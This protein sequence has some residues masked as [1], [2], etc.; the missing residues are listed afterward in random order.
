MVGPASRPAPSAREQAGP[1][2]ERRLDEGARLVIAG[3]LVF[4]DP[5]ALAENGGAG[6]AVAPR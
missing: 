5:D 2:G 3:A 1:L 4:A 6:F